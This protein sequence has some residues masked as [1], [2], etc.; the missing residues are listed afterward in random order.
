MDVTSHECPEIDIRVFL[1]LKAIGPEENTSTSLQATSQADR[2]PQVM[3]RESEY[4]CWGALVHLVLT[5][6]A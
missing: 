4:H 1:G 3:W 6:L 2:Q 5:P